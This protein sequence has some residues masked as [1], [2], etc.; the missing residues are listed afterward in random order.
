MDVAAA[1]A[2]IRDLQDEA[3]RAAFV[4]AIGTALGHPLLVRTHS[5]PRVFLFNVV[6]ACDERPGGMDALLMAVDFLAPGT[7]AASRIRQLVSPVREVLPATEQDRIRHLLVGRSTPSLARLYYVAAG[8]TVAS[9]PPRF[10]DA[11]QAFSLLLDSNADP[12]G[13]PPHLVFVELLAR[14]LSAQPAAEM[15]H[16]GDNDVAEQLREWVTAQIAVMRAEGGRDV[17]NRLY[18]IRNQPDVLSNRLDS[19][20]YLVIQLEPVTDLAARTRDLHR[21][22]HWRQID[23]F[24][25]RPER[26]EDRLVSLTEAPG[27]VAEL[28]RQAERDWAYPHDAAL[29]IEFVLPLML[30]NTAVDQWT[31]DPGEPFPAPIGAEYEVVV[32]S[33][34][35]LR[36]RAW[37][38]AWR[39]RWSTLMDNPR[40]CVTHWVTADGPADLRRLRAELTAR[41]EIVCCVLSCPPDSEPGQAELRMAL[42][43]GLPVVV[44]RRNDR[45]GETSGDSIRELIERLDIRMFPQEIRRL[46]MEA[47]LEGDTGVQPAWGVTLLW[48]DPGHFLDSVGPLRLPAR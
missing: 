47:N 25:W 44:W 8:V 24:E 2:E 28:V 9:T 17:S 19:P 36:E 40:D 46:R 14:A 33:H 34:D 48:D 45:Q 26:G 41:E 32:R 37:H 13:V 42:Q 22:S 15:P 30:I 1:L 4:H 20:M 7:A 38:R 3:G 16:H 18:R 5:S 6:V 39:R 29:V 10:A 27:H 21:L 12:D 11:W 35:R 31:A 43:A 23:P